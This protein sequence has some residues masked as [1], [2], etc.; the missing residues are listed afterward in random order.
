MNQAFKRFVK[1]VES[2]EKNLWLIMEPIESYSPNERIKLELLYRDPP[3]Q[4]ERVVGLPFSRVPMHRHPLVDSCEFHLA[5]EGVMTVGRRKMIIPLDL[6]FVP[7]PIS[8]NTWHGGSY[9]TPV[10]FLSV[11][12]WLGGTVGPISSDWEGRSTAVQIEKL[13]AFNGR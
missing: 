6:P 7:I 11:Q 5:G 4:I 3:Y 10:K 12:Y 13:E 1:W 8:H 9:V 2:K